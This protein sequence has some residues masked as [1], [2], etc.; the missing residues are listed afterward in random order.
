[1][2]LRRLEILLEGVAGFAHPS[3]AREQ[4]R[5][6]PPLA[7]RL[8]YTAFMA[9]DITGL[10]VLDLG[11]GTGILGIG[12]A[13]L[14]AGTVTGIEDDPG[15][16]TTAEE[17]ARNLQAEVEFIHA[18]V[19]DPAGRERVP[20]A[21]TI[22]MNPPFGAQSEHADRP[23]IDLALEKAG[24]VY[25]IFNAGSERFIREYTR[26]RAE[27]TAVIAAEC[28]IPRTFFFHTDDRREIPV[29]ILVL[30]RKKS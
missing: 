24:V 30:N 8:L 3:A 12:A 26:D 13:L 16:I 29:V 19:T 15:A 10:R 17:N 25:G 21:D 4:Y 11:S 2:R 22:I 6:P 14:G 18:D 20:L 28:T 27:I 5:T 9:G 7:A 23:F 1:M